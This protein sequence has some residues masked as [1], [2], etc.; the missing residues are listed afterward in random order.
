MNVIAAALVV[1]GLGTI[2]VVAS[3]L[4]VVEASERL[5]VRRFGRAPEIR[6]PGVRYLLPLADSG[7]RVPVRLQPL[8]VWFR[9]TTRDAVPVR[10]RALVTMRVD[11][12]VRY[13]RTGSP[14]AA[15]QAIIE[16]VLRDVIADRDL[17]DL[18]AL[19]ADGGDDPG[20]VLRVNRV[21]R[22]LGVV[23][24]LVSLTDA[25]VPVRPHDQKPPKSP[26][27]PKPPKSPPPKSQPPPMSPSPP[28]P[29]AAS[30]P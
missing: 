21:M 27:P 10:G 7:V 29:P 16:T 17:A 24:V 19:L 11:D 26:P 30:P 3:G 23:A 28:R 18:P 20:P 15:M 6:G 14:H 9:A 5:V 13:A 12:P 8:H 4:R 22:P 1:L 2:T 25:T